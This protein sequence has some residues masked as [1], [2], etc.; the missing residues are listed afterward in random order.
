MCSATPAWAVSASRSHPY[1]DSPRDSS[2]ERYVLAVRIAPRLAIITTLLAGVMAPIVSADTPSG[3]SPAQ[4][5]GAIDGAHS[6][7][8]LWATVNVCNS[9]S[10][11]HS[12]GIRGDRKSTRLNSSHL[13][14]S[15]AV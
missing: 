12:I 5:R 1:Y 15:Y 6:S 14:I 9:P 8:S 2:R 7:S 3:Y 11:P 13:G 4:I 10:D